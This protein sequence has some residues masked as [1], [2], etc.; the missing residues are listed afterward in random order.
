MLNG[1]RWFWAGRDIAYL[2]QGCLFVG[3][4]S[5]FI[6]YLKGSTSKTAIHITAGFKKSPESFAQGSWCMHC[7]FRKLLLLLCSLGPLSCLSAQ[8]PQVL[9][10]AAK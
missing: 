1:E 10:C 2:F 5:T 7:S 4:S 8:L 6:L 3:N 9:A